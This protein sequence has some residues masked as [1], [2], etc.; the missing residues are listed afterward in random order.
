MG[1][2]GLATVGLQIFFSLSP[3]LLLLAYDPQIYKVGESRKASV[4][5]ISLQ[6]DINSLN[7]L[8][9]ANALENLYYNDPSQAHLIARQASAGKSARHRVKTKVREY[10]A[11]GEGKNTEQLLHIYAPNM[12]VSLPYTI[13]RLN[14]K[15]KRSRPH[16]APSRYRNPMLVRIVDEF[17]R[18]VQAGRYQIWEM[19][20]FLAETGKLR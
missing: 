12:N 11:Q 8:Q 14:K 9:W 3:R 19:R 1:A 16:D 18:H 4:S 5:K 13:C 7:L 17:N 15:A 10:V 2:C 20:R 6:R